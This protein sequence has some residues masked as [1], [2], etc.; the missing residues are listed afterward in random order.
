M[1]DLI[2]HLINFALFV[3]L[4]TYAFK[5]YAA[6][7]L[8]QEMIAEELMHGSL[9]KRL[10]GLKKQEAQIAAARQHQK[11]FYEDLMAKTERWRTAMQLRADEEKLRMRQAV[12]KIQDRA[13][14][15]KNYQERTQFEAVIVPRALAA[16]QKELSRRFA[17]PAAAERFTKSITDELHMRV[18]R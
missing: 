6:T 1:I 14:V 18:N 13:C 9:H 11:A 16:A 2:F 7:P 5:K 15:Q 8:R 12:Q 3:A 4:C 17:E 10:E